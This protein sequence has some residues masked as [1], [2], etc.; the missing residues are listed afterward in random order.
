MSDPKK[1]TKFDS[2][3]EIAKSF[4]IGIDEK[5]EKS[6]EFIKTEYLNREKFELAINFSCYHHED[7]AKSELED[8]SRIG[9]FPFTE[10]E[11]E[12]EHAINH[13][14]IGSYKAAFADLRRALELTL[15]SAYLTSEQSN[16]KEAVEWMLSSTKTPFFSEMTKK[17]KRC[18]RFNDIDSK[19]N[20]EANLKRFYWEISDYSHNKGQLKGYRQLNKLVSVGTTCMFDTK[21]ES[22][23]I[24]CD[25]YIQTVGEIL[26]TLALYNPAIL[27]GMPL[28]EK[29]GLNPPA[30]GYYYDFQAALVHKLL[31]ETYKGYFR[32]IADNDKELRSLL[33]F[34]NSLPDL[35]EK[36]LEEQSKYWQQLAKAHKK[37]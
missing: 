28:A 7:A 13:A 21:N 11:M 33:E 27:V 6:L 19:C 1:A 12:L 36:D 3:E 37:E 4:I 10:A 17:L 31:P 30:S 29:F 26:V 2:L 25:F 24:F 32:D 34:F 8:L 23:S 35:S 9:H 18:Q 20:W 5:V 15:L 14:L 22:L 16:R